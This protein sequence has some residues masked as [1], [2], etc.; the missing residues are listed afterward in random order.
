MAHCDE[1]LRKI[2][3]AI[4]AYAKANGGGYPARLE[5]LV[6]AEAITAWDLVCSAGSV[7]IGKSSYVY[8]GSDLYETVP[9]EMVVAYD[10]GP[11]H[12]GRRNILFVNGEVKR[13]PERQFDRAISKDNQIRSEIGLEEKGF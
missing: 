5:E 13:P 8:R 12:K 10:I 6:E 9:E 2:F 11:W 1:S 3:G 4:R 7:P